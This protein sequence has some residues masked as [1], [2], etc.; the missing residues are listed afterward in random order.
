MKKYSWG[1][2]MFIWGCAQIHAQPQN[3][4]VERLPWVKGEFPKKQGSYEYMVAR[5]SG[6]T[7]A[8]ARD[9]ALNDLLIDL[10]NNAGVSVNSSTISE[11]KSQLNFDGRNTGYQEGNTT[12]SSFKIDREGFNASFSK[13]DEY[14][15][16]YGRGYELWVLYE[17]S[18]SG[19]SFKPYIPE[20]T[21]QYGMSAAW[22]S[23]IVPGWGQF[24]KGKTGKGIFF[25]STEVVAVSGIVFCEVK[26]SD[27]VRKSQE[28]TKLS[29]IKEYRNR[30]DNWELYRNIAIG[31]A[32][33][34]Y[35]WNV[36]DAALA[37]GKIH[38]A[39]LPDNLHLTTS[40]YNDL[41]YYGI[42]FKF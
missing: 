17:V 38:Y 3:S 32:A 36:L 1:F 10:G 16:R 42:G 35:L 37:K 23:V 12:I 18:Q 28:T 11:I 20:Y 7:L 8:E 25:L 19:K 15:E 4:H 21:D 30:A 31:T 6:S 33:G 9:N 14:Y 24:H 13:A 29:I 27:N 41:C 2:I 26:R 40:T 34:V 39:W 5:G 22:R